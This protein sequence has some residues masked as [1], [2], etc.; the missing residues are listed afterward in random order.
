VSR[1]RCVDAQ[2][3]AGFPVAAACHAARCRP[4]PSTPGRSGG[5]RGRRTPSGRR[6]S[7]SPRSASSTPTPMGLRGATDHRGAAPSWSAG[8]RKRVARLMAAHGLSATGPEAVAASPGPTRARH[9]HRTCSAAGSTPTSPTSP[10]AA[11]SPASRPI[12][13][14]CTWPL[15]ARPSLPPPARLVD[16]RPAHRRP[17]HQR[18]RRRRGDP[19]RQRTPWL[20]AHRDPERLSLGAACTGRHGG[21]RKEL[22]AGTSAR[23]SREGWSVPRPRRRMRG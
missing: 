21:D 22:A 14:G 3:A 23:T 12:R 11:I 8:H 19:R 20:G 6:P 16:G 2:K 9:Q 10:G 18:P 7:W 5:S 4:R 15:G 13:A 17:G 1:H